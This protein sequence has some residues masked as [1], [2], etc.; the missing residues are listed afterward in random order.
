MMILTIALYIFIILELFNV[1]IMYFRPGFPYGNSMT[2]FKAWHRSADDQNLHLFTTY[3]VRW[4]ANCKL[5]FIA[6]LVL[7]SLLGTD[8]LKFWTVIVTM[9]SVGVY[10]ITLHPIIRRLDERGEIQP[11]GYSKTLALMI[12]G[13]MLVFAVAL[14]LSVVIS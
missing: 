5:I 7:I 11:K 14:I 3:M 4:V 10:Y 1:V 6:L 13:F 2:V 9:L 8:A 12:G